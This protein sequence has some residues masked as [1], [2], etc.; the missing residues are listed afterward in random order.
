MVPWETHFSNQQFCL[1]LW[2]VYILRSVSDQTLY[3]GITT[4]ICTRLKKHNSGRGAKRTRNRGPWEVVWS[5]ECL[6]RS[7]A[8]KLEHSIKQMTKEQKLLLIQNL[9]DSAAE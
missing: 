9:R 2:F 7:E 4:D 6:D 8:S 3:T 1:M 5:K